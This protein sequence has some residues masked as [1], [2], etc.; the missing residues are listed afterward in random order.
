MSF[1][2]SYLA[3][4]VLFN[5]VTHKYSFISA[6]YWQKTKIFLHAEFM[7][8]ILLYISLKSEHVTIIKKKGKHDE[9]KTFL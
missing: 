9:S 7:E 4:K 3:I 2:S 1:M 6:Q 5:T 8:I